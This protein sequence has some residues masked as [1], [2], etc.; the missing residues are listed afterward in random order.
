MSIPKE[1]RQLMINLMYLVLTAL[2]AL[3]V[4][5]E[6][7]NAFFTLDDS[8]D[9]T[10]IVLDDAN[11]QVVRSLEATV[12]EK[13]NYKPLLEASRE[14]QTVVS[15]FIAYVDNI[16]NELDE[17]AGG[18]YPDDYKDK[19]KAGKPVRYRDKE[20]PTRY[21]V[22]GQEALGVKQE[23]KG[24]EVKAQIEDTRQKLID[25]VDRVSKM[26]IEGVII[27]PEDLEDIKSRISLAVD[28]Q[29]WQDYEKPSWEDFTFGHM[30]VA[31][32]YPI[33]RKFQNDAK[34]SEA[35]IINFLASKVGETVIE[36]DQFE[37]VAATRKSYII[38]GETYESEVFLSAFSTQAA[39]N[40]SMKVNGQ[41]LKI[42][43]GK[44]QY[45]IRPSTI[46]EKSYKVDI[47]LT[48]PLT[49][50]TEN[51][52][53]EFFY[54]VGERSVA[55]SADK[56]N[57]FYIGVDNPLSVSAAG[58]SSNDLRVSISGGGGKIKKTGSNNFMVNVAQ[59]T[60]NCKINVSGGGLQAT[61]TFRVKRIPDP[62]PQLG[63]LEE[64]NIKAGT[65][66]AQGGVLAILKNFDFEARCN[67]VGFEFVYQPKGADV[68]PVTNRGG[69]Y[70]DQASRLAERA[71][72][73]DTYYMRNIRAK[74][75]GDQITRKIG[76]MIFSIR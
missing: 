50:K 20:I 72:I 49:G 57:V 68:I 41:P 64:G 44:G 2:L 54:E 23:P 46:G 9:S 69:R 62:V 12:E 27:K 24:P 10:N 5:A 33:L 26:E 74:C 29:T 13:T 73:G 15:D 61:K 34:N 40:I 28:D 6:V 32:C 25:I 51:Y 35:T 30:P 48:N 38:K 56:M 37:P 16:R 14:A 31:A 58:V 36:F 53:K 39:E 4:S 65:F 70:G 43:N 1:P 11:K 60:Q 22:D 63:S 55:V 52:S 71:K 75:P 19:V 21:F 42:E 59:E 17:Q 7:M 67:I 45:S 66:K 47:S 3:N 76:S 8:I 18:L